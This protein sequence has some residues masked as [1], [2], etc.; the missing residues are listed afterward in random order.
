MAWIE[1]TATKTVIVDAPLE[2]IA[3]FFATPAQIK[4]CMGDLERFEVVD[5][6]TYR[7]ILKAMG[8]KGISFQGDY[9][10]RYWREGDVVR[11][12]SL[13]GGTMK[14]TGQVRLRELGPGRT[15]VTYDETLA[16]DLPIPRLGAKVFR[17]IVA[18]EIVRGVDSFLDG[19]RTYLNAGKHRSGES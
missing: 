8:A 19:V 1:G 2:E 9:T 3:T 12:E 15:E 10:V 6:T 13:P 5:E 17:P 11:W 7:W 14:T 16:S 4:E 18:R